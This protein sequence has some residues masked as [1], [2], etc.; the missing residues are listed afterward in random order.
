ML[1]RDIW[2][3]LTDPRN[4][5]LRVREE[6]VPL[7]TLYLKIILPLAVIPPVSA[8]IGAAVFGWRVAGP[9]TVRLTTTSA[10]G[11]SI[12]YF[13]AI[14]VAIFTLG[15]MVAWM[16]ETYGNKQ[17]LSRCIALIAYSAIPLFLVS[18]FQL[19]PVIWVNFI[20]GLPALA[21]S[22]F[23][24]YCGVPIVMNVS[25]ERGFLFASAVL[26][27][28]LV[29]L[30]GLLVTSVMLWSFGLGPAFII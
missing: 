12:A 10:T 9:N 26:A 20:V 1:F 25:P 14:L 13:L 18:F 7:S 15:Y 4:T 22:V 11:I 2:G 3:M 21:Y 8:W 28:S 16:S 24:L 19:Y 23:L 30:V 27:I 5:W 17:P 29:A 6:S